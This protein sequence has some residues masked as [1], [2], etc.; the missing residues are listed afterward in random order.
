MIFYA[1]VWFLD[2]AQVLLF[3]GKL[4]DFK[5]KRLYP[6]WEELLQEFKLLQLLLKFYGPDNEYRKALLCACYPGRE[7]GT[8]LNEACWDLMQQLI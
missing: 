7:L 2:A 1:L 4:V 5:F 3:I 8:I 6:A